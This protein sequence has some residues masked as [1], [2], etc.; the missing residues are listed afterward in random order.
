M[1]G[2][3]GNQDFT[4]GGGADQYQFLWRQGFEPNHDVIHGFS[5][6]EGDVIEFN[7]QFEGI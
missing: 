1:E 2:R 7:S 3:A 6:A 5:V 4:G